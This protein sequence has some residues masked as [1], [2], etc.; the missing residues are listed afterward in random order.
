LAGHAHARIA[1]KILIAAAA[2]TASTGL[3]AVG[4][5][6]WD[7]EREV[8]VTLV[9]TSGAIAFGSATYAAAEEVRAQMAARVREKVAFVL[10]A[11]A[12]D[13]H[14][15]TDLDV[16]DIG[17]SAYV[18]RRAWWRPWHE[19]LARMHRERAAWCAATSGI[20]W[21]PGMGVVGRCVSEAQDVAVDLSSVDEQLGG[22]ARREWSRVEPDLRMGM[23]WREYHKARGKYGVVLASPIIDDR[24][25]PAR[26]RGCVAVD[27]PAG[28][29]GRITADPVRERVASAATAVLRLVL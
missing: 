20:Q 8:L 14:D 4:V 27:A 15:A 6:L 12:F 16:R 2:A 13:L 7:P 11:L 21:R 26:V 10:R 28:S 3:T 18:R 5:R 17:V 25:S 22:V 19:Y 1:A 9:A 23:S 29:M 24:G